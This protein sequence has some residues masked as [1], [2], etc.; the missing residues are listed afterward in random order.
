MPAKRIKVNTSKKP[1]IDWNSALEILEEAFSYGATDEQ[2]CFQAGISADSLYGYCRK[3]PEYLKRK[4]ALKNQ[5]KYFAKRNISKKVKGTGK[6]DGDIDTSKYI[7]D[8]TDPD[9]KPKNK[10]EVEGMLSK[11]EMDA[12]AKRTADYLDEIHKNDK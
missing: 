1:I 7:L 2:A 4:D 10:F 8:R 11:E 12:Q 3:H 6:G 9:F 5:T